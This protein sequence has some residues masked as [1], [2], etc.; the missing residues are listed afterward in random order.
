MEAE[1]RF[2]KMLPNRDLG[3][4]LLTARALGRVLLID[5]S[6]YKFGLN[7]EIL[8]LVFTVWKPSLRLRYIYLST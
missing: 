1:Q 3:T 2:K 6:T 7:S 5:F 8:E 4:V